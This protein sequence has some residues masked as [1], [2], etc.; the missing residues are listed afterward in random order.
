MDLYVLKTWKMRL[1]IR[2]VALIILQ[3]L[4][5][6]LKNCSIMLNEND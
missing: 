3:N 1:K 2:F 4:K 6:A 5:N